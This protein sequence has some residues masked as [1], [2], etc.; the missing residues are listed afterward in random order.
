MKK[1]IILLILSFVCLTM[2]SASV[3]AD[4]H[5]FNGILDASMYATGGK[6]HAEIG[7]FWA[8]YVNQIS[9]YTYD[10]T[11][12]DGLKSLGYIGTN[13][14][15]GSW[16][17]AGDIAAGTEIVA[18]ILTPEGTSYYSGH[19]NIF[20]SNGEL[21]HSKV[22]FVDQ[23]YTDPPTTWKAVSVGFE[24]LRLTGS[25]KDF[26]DAVTVSISGVQAVPEPTTIL[27]A[28]SILAPAGLMFRRRKQA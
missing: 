2:I 3:F 15:G 16:T 6:I 11:G 13:Y 21:G 20:N 22:S 28:F 8:G 10:G 14:S 24:D 26:N 5:V 7:P 19:A 4:G 27:A 9:L 25:D 17:S 12:K 23:V 18:G 1:L